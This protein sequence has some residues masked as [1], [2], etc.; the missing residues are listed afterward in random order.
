MVNFM[1]R[2]VNLRTISLISFCLFVLVG[3]NFFNSALKNPKLIIINVLD[4]NEFDDC[5]IAGSVNIPFAEFENKVASFDKNDHYILYCADYA[6]MSSGYCAKLLRDK[7]YKN[8]WEYS[9]GI[10]EWY[11]KG[12]PTQGPA[13]EEYLKFE[14]VNYNDEENLT[15][16]ITAEELLVKI[17]Q[18]SSHIE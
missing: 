6:C 1:L 2:T 12:Y 11:Q 3:C 5:H 18:F 15:T 16:T 14:N 13:Q 7:N 10:V 17:E 4:K 9:G 8:V